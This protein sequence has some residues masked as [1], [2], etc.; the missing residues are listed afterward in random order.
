MKLIG[1]TTEGKCLVEMGVA[2]ANAIVDLGKAA[3]EYAK[4]ETPPAT[5]PVAEATPKPALSM[6]PGSKKDK[7]AAPAEDQVAQPKRKA[8]R[9]KQPARAK[10]P[11]MKHSG[12]IVWA[13]MVREALEKAGKP[14]SVKAMFRAIVAQHDTI[15]NN[16]TNHARINA[17]VVKA[18]YLERVSPGVYQLSDA[19]LAADP[20]ELSDDDLKRR[21]DLDK[22][23]GRS[24]KAA[25]LEYMQ[26]RA[27]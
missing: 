26:R 24:D 9:R 21:L 6:I 5:G 3:L 7:G 17:H 4:S 23:E 25:R 16:R 1:T 13:D 8:S 22:K 27:E 10:Q 19:L 18:P 11:A 14:L 2:E 12:R 15:E 20:H